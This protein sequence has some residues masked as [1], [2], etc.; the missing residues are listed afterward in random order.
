MSSFFVQKCFEQLLCAQ[1]LGVSFF[2]Q[3]EIRAKA[4]HEMLVKLI[5]DFIFK[6][7]REREEEE[8]RR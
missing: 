1:S 4:A 8:D 6:E 2:R 5:K 7:E 3:K